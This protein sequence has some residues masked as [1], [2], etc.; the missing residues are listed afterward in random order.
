MNCRVSK[1][2]ENGKVKKYE[3]FSSLNRNNNNIILW[4]VGKIVDKMQIYHFKLHIVS[5]SPLF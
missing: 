3:E 1:K 4:G 5:K 2:S